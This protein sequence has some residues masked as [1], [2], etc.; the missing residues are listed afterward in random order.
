MNGAYQISLFFFVGDLELQD[1]LDFD[2]GTFPSLL[3]NFDLIL[4]LENVDFEEF[5]VRLLD[6]HR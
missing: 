5:R 2:E 3:D 6:L 1:N 4:R